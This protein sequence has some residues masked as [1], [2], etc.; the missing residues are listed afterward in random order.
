MAETT[1][2]TT[3]PAAD[4][5]ATPAARPTKP[6]ENAFKAD[7]AKAEKDHKESMDRF[8]S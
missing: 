3:A 6:D 2:T 8:V 7:L 1:T 4:N 5:K